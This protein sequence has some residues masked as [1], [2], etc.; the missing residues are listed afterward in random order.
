MYHTACSITTAGLNRNLAILTVGTSPW[1]G[2]SYFHHD[3]SSG[4]W[5]SS[6]AINLLQPPP[7]WRRQQIAPP[8]LHT[9][10]LFRKLLVKAHWV[11]PASIQ[12]TAAASV[13]QHHCPQ[14]AV[15]IPAPVHRM[16]TS[17]TSADVDC[18]SAHHTGEVAAEVAAEVAC[19]RTGQ[20]RTRLPSLLCHLAT[21]G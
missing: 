18:T 5:L 12:T 21:R 2:P 14:L 8:S 9:V 17:A 6:L 10:G 19:K 1:E 13:T 16:Y 4:Q 3:S 11:P 15:V 20:Q 7:C